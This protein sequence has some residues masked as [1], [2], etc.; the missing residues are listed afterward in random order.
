[1][2]PQYA[3]QPKFEIYEILYLY[4][5]MWEE[6]YASAILQSSHFAYTLF[7]PDYNSN[8]PYESF[9]KISFQT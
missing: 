8:Y 2:S 6:S 3:P 9:V 5:L 1:M 4:S 7:M